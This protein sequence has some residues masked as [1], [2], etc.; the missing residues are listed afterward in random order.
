MIKEAKTETKKD[1]SIKHA[2]KVLQGIVVGT[3]MQDTAKVAITRFVKH[4]K[5]KKFIKNVKNYLVHDEGN[6]TKVGDRV[7]IQ[8]TKPISKNKHFKII[9]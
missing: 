7:N 8:E 5:Y 6:N 4:P 1:L 9:E 2:G 3:A